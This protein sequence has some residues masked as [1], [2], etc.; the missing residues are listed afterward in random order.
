MD[1]QEWKILLL[2]LVY[3]YVPALLTPTLFRLAARFR[4]DGVRLL[5]ALT[6]HALFAISFSIVHCLGMLGIRA[7]IMDYGGKWPDASWTSYVQRLY[8][9]NLDWAL[10]VYAAIVG[11]SYAVTYYR[12]SQA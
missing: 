5:R 7:V 9:Q 3:W 11:L 1:I 6:L 4:L 10:M 8:L 12:E 2:N